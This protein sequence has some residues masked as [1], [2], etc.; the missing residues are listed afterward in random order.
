MSQC[1]R[2]GATFDLTRLQGLVPLGAR[3]VG[4]F[5]CNQCGCS[6]AAGD[7]LGTVRPALPARNPSPVALRR[8]RVLFVVGALVILGGLVAA[9][10]VWHFRP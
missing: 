10:L 7:V 8:P 1:P 5:R 3:V 6:V 4:T 2:C 9:V